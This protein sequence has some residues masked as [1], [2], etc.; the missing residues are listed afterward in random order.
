MGGKLDQV[1]LVANAFLETWPRW[2]SRTCSSRPPSSRRPARRGDD[3]AQ[4]DVGFL[5]RQGADHQ[6]FAS[7]VLPQPG[8]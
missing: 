4:E 6:Y 1:T 8:A 7:Y 2:R 5:S 3:L